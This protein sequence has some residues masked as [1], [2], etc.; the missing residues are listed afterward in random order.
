MSVSSMY[1]APPYWALKSEN[2]EFS[3]L[4][5]KQFTHERAPPVIDLPKFLLKVV[6]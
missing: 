5:V 2:W 1:I 4:I 6:E 3:I